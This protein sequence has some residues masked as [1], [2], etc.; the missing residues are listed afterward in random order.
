MPPGMVI[1]DHLRCLP[2]GSKSLCDRK[3]YTI[4]RGILKESW[5]Q[6]QSLLVVVHKLDGML[7]LCMDFRKVATFDALP[8]PH[9]KEMV[10]KIR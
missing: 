1:Q 6:W 9:I 7:R 3:L 2:R 4:A 8:V 5:S 10:E